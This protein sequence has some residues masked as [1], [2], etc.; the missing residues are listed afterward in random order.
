M[1]CPNVYI[2]SPQ[3]VALLFMWINIYSQLMS[4]TNKFQQNFVKITNK[5]FYLLNIVNIKIHILN[6]FLLVVPPS[7]RNSKVPKKVEVIEYK[8]LQLECVT[9]G[10]PDPEVTWMKNDQLIDY[11]E[12]THMRS[13]RDENRALLQVIRAESEDTGTYS[14]QASNPAGEAIKTFDISVHGK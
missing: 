3:V 9:S 5:N 13:I 8:P 7:I 6:F 14:C 2:I 1:E 11:S 10:V 4:I 12:V